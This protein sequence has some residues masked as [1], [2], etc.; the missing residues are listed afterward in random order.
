VPCLPEVCPPAS[1]VPLPLVLEHRQEP[2][3]LPR[4]VDV[5]RRR[6]HLEETPNPERLDHG[7]DAILIGVTE[8]I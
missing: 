3:R 7:V 8:L 5:F 2:Q 6:L 4:R 1:A